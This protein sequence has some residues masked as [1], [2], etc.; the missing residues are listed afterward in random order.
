MQNFTLMKKL[1][2]LLTISICGISSAQ[3]AEIFEDG[4]K[5]GLKTDFGKELLPADYVSIQKCATDTLDFFVCH[6]TGAAELY[7]YST[8]RRDIYDEVGQKPFTVIKWQWHPDVKANQ[9]Y[10]YTST[11]EKYHL[12]GHGWEPVK[13]KGMIGCKDKNGK[14]AVC[15]GGKALSEYKYLDV[16]AKHKDLAV[17]KTDTGWVA[18]D[19]KMKSHYEWSFDKI[20]DSDEHPEAFVIE[21][22]NKFGVLSL[23]D[24]LHIPPVEMKNPTGMFEIE[25]GIAYGILER[26]F[27]VKRNGK[28]GVIDHENNVQVPFKYDNAYMIDDFAIEQHGLSVHAVVKEGANWKFLNEK[29]DEHKSIQFDTWLGTH[30]AVGLVIKGGKVWQIDL[31]SFEDAANLYFGE[32]QDHEIVKSEDGVS[33]VVGKTGDILIPFEY[34]WIA[35]EGDDGDEFFVADKGSKDGIYSLDGKNLVPHNYEDLI[36][37]EKKNDKNYFSIGKPGQAALAYWD[38]TTNKMIILSDRIYK[39]VSYDYSDKHFTCETMDGVYHNLNDEGKMI[40]DE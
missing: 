14:Y 29:W 10:G 15:M 5:F 33:G 38:K 32:Y 2:F 36:F 17:C 6:T 8:D 23:D 19:S 4:G 24:K 39:N 13:V 9:F 30:G 18:L 16:D 21:K 28:W 37:L 7:S 35:Q 34:K 22:G 12:H 26:S 27:A 1:L 25:D 40:E 11:G 20:H 31:K 3:K